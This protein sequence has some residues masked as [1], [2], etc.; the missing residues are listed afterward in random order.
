MSEGSS[1]TVTSAGIGYKKIPQKYGPSQHT[2]T[3][4]VQDW[5]F[6]AWINAGA[7]SEILTK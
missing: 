6:G 5:T 1:S 3:P 2:H 4:H 7:I